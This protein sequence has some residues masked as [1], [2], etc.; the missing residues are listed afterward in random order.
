MVHC[1]HNLEV[2]MS[3]RMT[4][5]RL[6][7]FICFAV[8][9]AGFAQ[10]PPRPAPKPEDPE[11]FDRPADAQEHYRRKRAPVGETAIPVERYFAALQR[12]R[13]MPQRSTR[14]NAVLPSR[15]ELASQGLSYVAAAEA[16]GAWSPLG[17]GNVGGRTRALLIDPRAP[18]T[19]YA[20]GVAGGVWKSIDGG[21][22]WRPLDDLMANLAVVS[23]AMDPASSNVLYAGTGEGFFN[24]DAV[25]GAGIFK[26]TDGGLTWTRLPATA[27][28]D[29]HYVNDLA[30]STRDPR[31]VYAATRTGVWRSLD[32]G[33][34][35]TRVL[36]PKAHGGCLDLALRTDKRADA[37]LASC[38]TLEESAGVWRNQRAEQRGKWTRV[39]SEKGLGRTSLA[40]APSKQDVIYALASTNL[41]GPDGNYRFGLHAVL[42]SDDGGQTWSARVR[43][44]DPVKLNTVLLT[45]PAFAFGQQCFSEE[46]AFYNQGW[47]DSVIAVDPVNPDRVW[48]G[49]IDLFRSDDGGRSWGLAS[50]WWATP[51]A[52]SYAHAD[53]H[54]IVFHPRYNGTS[55]KTL[56][57]SN[58]GGIFRTRDALA[59]TV[60][61]AAGVC[62]P[63]AGQ[64]PWTSLDN[65]YG[66]T[67][68]YNGASYP[69]GNTWFGG[70]QDNGTIRGN[71]GTGANTWKSLLRGDGGYVAVDPDDTDIVYGTYTDLSI[72]KSTDG[73][74]SFAPATSGI[75]EAPE[76]FLFI[77]PFVMDPSD[78][79]RLWTGGYFLWRTDDGA[80]QW[81]RAS[82]RLSG[83]AP[84]MSAVAVSPTDPDRVMAGTQEGLLASTAQGLSAGPSTVWQQVKPRAGWV[85]SVAFD[86]HDPD[87]AYATYSTFGGTHVWK[88]TDGGR[89]WAGLDGT[90]TGRLPDLPVHV[91]VVDPADSRTLFL[92]TDLG[93]FVSTDGGAH[94]AVENTGF[95]NVVTE[96]LSILSAGGSR[97]LFAFTHG[98]GAWKVTITD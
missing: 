25:R 75:D 42:R 1:P 13:V 4:P 73:G 87:V 53:Q 62:D 96:S 18:K 15:A 95:A 63:A 67:Q 82:A 51:G 83:T 44:T 10:A 40:I 79:D 19:M 30:V 9:A 39:I 59:P 84:S 56:F 49:G 78:S 61:T 90:G 17:P 65:G 37:L 5:I 47:Y 23:L 24:S 34:A 52:P 38:G 21:A 70:A 85:S 20:A 71:Q 6:G 57:V 91:L 94:W 58:D 76:G 31:R 27:S 26:T 72:Q 2:L 54:A 41:P 88:S 68:F 74:V 81:R 60:K 98:R 29:F 69:D 12:M 28:P 35:W 66:V 97:M 86:P 92:G 48:A 50:Y 33:A 3:L 77:T 7:L 43:N 11:W 22:S 45:N 55:V 80:G 46:D 32:A 89:T 93:I 14:R 64:V 8:S 36:D 16:L